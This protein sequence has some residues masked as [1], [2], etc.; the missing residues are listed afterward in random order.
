MKRNITRRLELATNEALRYKAI[1]SE[2]EPH[3]S[4]YHFG[5]AWRIQA[6]PK[7]SASRLYSPLVLRFLVA[8]SILF[9]VCLRLRKAIYFVICQL[10]LCAIAHLPVRLCN[11]ATCV[12]IWQWRSAKR[13]CAWQKSLLLFWVNPRSVQTFSWSPHIKKLTSRVLSDCY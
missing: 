9:W 3:R 2:K 7:S 11:H 4:Q 6:L 12:Q 5:S 1:F 8:E 13:M 10:L